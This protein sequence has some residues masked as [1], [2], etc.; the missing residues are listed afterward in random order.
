MPAGE[1]ETAR[2]FFSRLLGLS[3]VVKPA[4][5][6][7]GADAG[8]KAEAL[9]CIFGVRPIST[10]PPRRIKPSWVDDLEALRARLDAAGLPYK[11][12]EPL[13]GFQRTYVSD[14][15]GNRIELMELE[16]D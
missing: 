10:L 8:S 14:P 5:L 2:G 11:D 1:E 6:A 13:D 12:D 15:F 16:N 4:N 9:G 3:E 7:N